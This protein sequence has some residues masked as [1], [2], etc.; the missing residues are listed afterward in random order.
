M[1]F[2]QHAVL[3]RLM[4]KKTLGHDMVNAARFMAHNGNSSFPK[5]CTMDAPSLLETRELRTES[6]AV[7][8][9]LLSTVLTQGVRVRCPLHRVRCAASFERDQVRVEKFGVPLCIKPVVNNA[10]SGCCALPAGV[11]LS[12]H[13]QHHMTSLTRAG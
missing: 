3:C 12:V 13:G 4:N 6:S 10:Q 7:G 9:R 8:P 5:T 2:Q 1:V 11:A